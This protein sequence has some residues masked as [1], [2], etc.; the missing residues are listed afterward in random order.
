MLTLRKIGFAILTM[1]VLLPFAYGQDKKKLSI[2]EF[3]AKLQQTPESQLVDVRTPEESC[4][5][6]FE[7]QHQ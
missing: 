6:C 1:I 3:E 2:D 5:R 7:R 4:E